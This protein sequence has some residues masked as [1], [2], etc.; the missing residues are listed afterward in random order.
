MFNLFSGIFAITLNAP[1]SST[2]FHFILF[3]SVLEPIHK[4]ISFLA[5]LTQRVM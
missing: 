2:I 4:N 3:Y 5:D 1:N